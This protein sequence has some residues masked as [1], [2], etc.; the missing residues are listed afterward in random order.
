MKFPPPLVV[1]VAL[2]VV[3][4]FSYGAFRLPDHRP[5]HGAQEGAATFSSANHT[6]N[7]SQDRHQRGD[8]G[9]E[10]DDEVQAAL[11]LHRDEIWRASQAAVKEE[12]PEGPA[13]GIA[14]TSSFLVLASREE[15]EGLLQAE[16]PLHDA[17]FN[18]IAA[19]LGEDEASFLMQL[20]SKAGDWHAVQTLILERETRTGQ[21][22]RELLLGMG[23]ATGQIPVDDIL[24]VLNT[25]LSMPEG[26][27][28]VLALHGRVEDIAFLAHRTPFPD[29]NA[30]D[31]VMGHTA[32]GS[33]VQHYFMAAS[34]DPASGVA[35]LRTLIDLGID[36]RQAG[37]QLDVLSHIFLNSHPGNRPVMEALSAYVIQSGLV[38]RPEELAIWDRIATPAEQQALREAFEYLAG[39]PVVPQPLP[40]EQK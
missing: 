11:L 7:A 17:L 9:A 29:L 31:P 19:E 26:A 35:S 5:G 38:T 8:T 39:L 20:V 10:G 4:I 12:P 28:H 33:L 1:F 3:I 18:G 37:G 16:G 6:E 22:Y 14:Q 36:T 30:R 2:L 21:D 15:L 40:R 32:I 27:L 13:D 25:G 23:L 34:A 24:A